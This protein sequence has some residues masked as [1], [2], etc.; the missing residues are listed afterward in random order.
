MSVLSRF[1]GCRACREAR[2][3]SSVRRTRRY[4]W[5]AL[6][7]APDPGP[8]SPRHG[9]LVPISMGG[10]DGLIARRQPESAPADPGHLEAL[11]PTWAM[12]QP[13]V[14]E[15]YAWVELYQVGN[16]RRHPRW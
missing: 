14:A 4:T 16:F 5:H 11:V 1:A 12:K 8:A 10:A 7:S 6:D 3:N 13:S 2:G 15:S 9:R